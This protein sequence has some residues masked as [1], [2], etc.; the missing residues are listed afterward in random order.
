MDNLEAML[1]AATPGPWQS[2]EMKACFQIHEAGVRCGYQRRLAD[3]IYWS[4]DHTGDSRNP[5]FATAKA[6]ATLIA[7]APDLAA[8]VLRLRARIAE[9]DADLRWQ[10][11]ETI[12]LDGTTV[13]VWWTYF[14]SPRFVRY[15]DGG[16]YSGNSVFQSMG[17]STIS[18]LAENHS[19]WAAIGSPLYRIT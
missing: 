11:I 3:V 14:G 7:M 17:I 10:P 19:H 6:N 5:L 13:L 12:P 8:E 9:L 16:W 4:A 18:E 2:H 15:L 1:A